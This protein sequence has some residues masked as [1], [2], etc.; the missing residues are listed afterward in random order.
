MQ[1]GFLPANLPMIV[2]KIYLFFFFLVI[3][4]LP[5]KAFEQTNWE[6]SLGVNQPG[7]SFYGGYYGNITQESDIVLFDDERNGGAS[8]G[9]NAGFGVLF[10]CE[11]WG[12]EKL[13]VS[14]RTDLL[15]NGINDEAK[16]CIVDMR[17]KLEE[18]YDESFR[19]KRSPCYIN[20][21]IMTGLR[22]SIPL[23]ECINIF[24][25][26]NVGLNIRM[27]TPLKIESNGIQLIRY[28]ETK[29][30]IAC[31]FGCGIHVSKH[32]SISAYLYELGKASVNMT[33]QV[34][35]STSVSNTRDFHNGESLTIDM[36]SVAL[37][38]SF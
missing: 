16:A 8:R 14:L 19:T 3:I 20:M 10:P 2:K 12:I 9:F 6:I 27:I 25:E 5:G 31:R 36:W 38:Y 11:I 17:K 32:F 15:Y 28:Y 24:I 33:T 22:Y 13:F 37:I 21:P 29:G 7:V 23:T 30:T 34:S 4:F 26:A 18:L 1:N 35:G